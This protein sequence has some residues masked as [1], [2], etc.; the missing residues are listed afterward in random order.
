MV[1]GRGIVFRHYHQSM[2][3]S[4]AKDFR[5]GEKVTLTRETKL[6]PF[7]EELET[8]S[9]NHSSPAHTS[10][11][12][13]KKYQA[14]HTKSVPG[15]LRYTRQQA[16]ELRRYNGTHVRNPSLLADT[17]THTHTW[18]KRELS[19]TLVRGSARLFKKFVGVLTRGTGQ[20]FVEGMDVPV[21]ERICVL[22][23][24]ACG[25]VVLMSL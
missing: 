12:H 20:H 16:L 7:A 8:F 21:L 18:V 23:Y 24:C 5:D 4:A 13:V 11:L 25:R 3:K 19:V 14:T 9:C 1:Q 22:R 2:A 10:A 6:A 15:I 17:H